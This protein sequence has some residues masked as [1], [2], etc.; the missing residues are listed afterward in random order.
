MDEEGKTT[1]A[2]D[3]LCLKRD[4]A[5]AETR[6]TRGSTTYDR[7]V[8]C[9]HLANRV[10]RYRALGRVVLLIVTMIAPS[11]LAGDEVRRTGTYV[12][13]L[14]GGR[15][16]AVSILHSGVLQDQTL[17]LLPFDRSIRDRRILRRQRDI[18]GDA[19]IVCVAVGDWRF[20]RIHRNFLVVLERL[21]LDRS[22]QS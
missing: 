14:S 4:A 8:D 13:R 3:T 1:A 22:G 9:I 2:T 6:A 12:R 17:D 16:L 20:V 11:V 7:A 19:L 21:D 15:Q 18:F 5:F 10:R